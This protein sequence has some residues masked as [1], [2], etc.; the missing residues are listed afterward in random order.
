MRI[1][2]ISSHQMT[3]AYSRNIHDGFPARTGS[4]KFNAGL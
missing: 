3:L 4:Y 2:P 1:Q